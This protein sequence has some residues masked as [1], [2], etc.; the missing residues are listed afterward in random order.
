MFSN[1]NN[2]QKNH[3]I[4]RNVFKEFELHCAH[5]SHKLSCLE[6]DKKIKPNHSYLSFNVTILPGAV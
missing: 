1:N 5:D 3:E 2:F 4:D 6:F